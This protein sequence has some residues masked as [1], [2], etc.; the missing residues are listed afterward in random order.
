MNRLIVRHRHRYWYTLIAAVLSLFA[1]AALASIQEVRAA[2]EARSQ[3]ERLLTV[4]DRGEERVF[5]TT[6]ATVGEALKRADIDIDKT[7][8]VEP[9]LD[10]ELIASD[11]N[12]NVYR[13]RPVIVVDGASRHKTMTSRQT[14]EQIADSAGLKLYTEDDA[15]LQMSDNMLMSGAGLE[16]V[17]S[18]ATPLTLVL[19][20]KAAEIRTQA[21]TV[22]ELLEEKNIKLGP[23]D[24]ASAAMGDPITA[25]MTLELWR[26]GTQTVTEEQ[27]V[28]FETEKIQDADRE[29]G[30]REVKQ[31]GEAGKRTVTYEIEIKNGQEVS[32][33]EIA[34]VTTVQPKKQIEVV[35]AKFNYTGGPL[36]EAQITALGMC[37][38]GM[39]P[40]RNSGN[41][42][43]GAFQFMPATWRTVAPAE[44]KGVLPHEA[45][46]E[47]QKQAVQTLLSRSSIYTQFPGCA[48]K[49]TAQGIL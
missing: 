40:T 25:G 12:V 41:G 2:E 44:Y 34:S 47:A 15:K 10:E 24:Q 19:Y 16:L 23:D 45:P 43:Y 35:G 1:M 5:L 11:Y 28:A 20:G 13:A 30:Y 4:Y 36:S 32:R 6:A 9:S 17:I 42:F 14:P 29:A 18:R 7:D 39:T 46:L 37:E 22:G 31:T 48:K 27:D 49:M 3:G 8:T 33:K 26:D 21:K 38:S